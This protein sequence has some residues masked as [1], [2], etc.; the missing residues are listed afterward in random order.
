VALP[1]LGTLLDSPRHDVVAVI[2]RPAARAGRGRREAVSP[3]A[4]LAAQAGLPV[5]TPARAG[6]P[7]FLAT[8]DDLAVDC[9]PVV[10]YGALLPPAP[11]DG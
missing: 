6:Q 2:T 5:L 9:C 7:D 11:Q 1:S 8:L 3:V 4:E 10:G